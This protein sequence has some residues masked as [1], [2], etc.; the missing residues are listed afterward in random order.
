M[1]PLGA[2]FST[3]KILF[4]SLFFRIELGILQ[5]ISKGTQKHFIT[6]SYL[7][8][9]ASMPPPYFSL[10]GSSGHNKASPGVTET[11][12]FSSLL[13]RREAKFSPLCTQQCFPSGTTQ[14]VSTQ[15]HMERYTFLIL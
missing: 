6:L 10:S 3:C 14:T 8:L 2:N 5:E 12:I 1:V 13:L 11:K 9:T 4:F 7:V 15:C